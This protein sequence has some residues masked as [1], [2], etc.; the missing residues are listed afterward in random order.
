[1]SFTFLGFTFK[2][3]GAKTRENRLF[4]GYLPAISEKAKKRIGEKL[5]EIGIRNLTGS[6]LWEVSQ[7]INEFVDGVM[8]YYGK[9][10]K[11]A[12]S[13]ILHR[14]EWM[15]GVWVRRKYRKTRK[16]TIMWLKSIYRREQSIFSHWKYIKP[17]YIVSL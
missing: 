11:S 7:K 2:G 13:Q 15:I 10:Y 1:M 8:N 12:M 14:I 5:R 6:S 17:W 9:F 3:R 4:I 16:E